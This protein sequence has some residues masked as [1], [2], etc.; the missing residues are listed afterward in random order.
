MILIFSV[1]KRYLIN[2]SKIVFFLKWYS[3]F[4]F[5][6]LLIYLTLMRCWL[7]TCHQEETDLQM[8]LE[9]LDRE[10]NLHIRE[11]KRIHNEDNS[12]YVLTPFSSMFIM[13]IL[14]TDTYPYRSFNVCSKNLMVDQDSTVSL[15]WWFSSFSPLVCLTV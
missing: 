10:R 12:K 5:P 8:E 15:S 11:S 7:L 14:S 13:L 1:L 6:F 3:W 2:W 9:K 4:R